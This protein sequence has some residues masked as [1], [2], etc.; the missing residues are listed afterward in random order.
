M[1]PLSGLDSG[2]VVLGISPH[3]D[4]QYFASLEANGSYVDQRHQ[5]SIHYTFSG[6]NTRNTLIY[7]QLYVYTVYHNIWLFPP[8]IPANTNMFSKLHWKENVIFPCSLQKKNYVRFNASLN[9]DQWSPAQTG[10]L[11][12][13][14]RFIL[15]FHTSLDHEMIY[16]QVQSYY[17]FKETNAIKDWTATHIVR[18]IKGHLAA[19][20]TTFLTI[21]TE[22]TKY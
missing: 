18:L 4:L 6:K 7:I 14:Y 11:Q 5:F 21:T 12:V 16:K 22:K 15:C 10:C 1:C 2:S 8:P 20:L 17:A 3:P 19:A 13:R 9:R